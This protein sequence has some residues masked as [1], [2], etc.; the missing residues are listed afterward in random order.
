MTLT[1]DELEDFARRFWTAKQQGDSETVRDLVDPNIVWK[2]VG[3]NA[4]I[5]KTY[6]G[7]EE[8]F[9]GLGQALANEFVPGDRRID[10]TAIYADEIHQTAIV[11]L[12]EEVPTKSGQ[13][14]SAEIVQIMKIS[15]VQTLIRCDEYMDLAE[16]LRTFD[17]QEVN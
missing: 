11:C 12:Y 1:R 6:V 7:A 9:T 17:N 5:A 14:F 2:I 16:V 10:I 15:A 8:Y 13:T 4:K 3:H